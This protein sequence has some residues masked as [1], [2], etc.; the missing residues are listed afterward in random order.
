MS[1]K[2]YRNNPTHLFLDQTP[3]FVTGAIYG[4]RPLLA[5]AV[6]KN[7]LLLFIQK[8]FEKYG[9]ELH[10][11]VILDNHY[12]LLGKSSQGSHLPDIFRAIHSQMAVIIRANTGCETPVWWNYWDYCPRGEADYYIRL[13]YLLSNPIKHGFVTNLADYPHSSFPA[14]LAEIGREQLAQQ[15]RAYPE[16][17]IL[18]LRE[19]C[20]DDF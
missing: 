16:Y 19:A 6:L 11:W 3:Y 15:F 1:L 4:K 5:D 8:Y 10:H 20:N 7:Q 13:N 18:K 2:K 9:W 14:A 17:K 12:H